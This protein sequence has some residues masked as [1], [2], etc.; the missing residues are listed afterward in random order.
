MR[1]KPMRAFV[2]RQ[3]TYGA[4]ELMEVAE[5][6]SAPG[7]VKI[8]IQATALCGSD[9]HADVSPIKARAVDRWGNLVYRKTGRNFGPLM[10]T[11]ARCTIVQ[12]EEIVELGELD[13]ESIVTPGIFVHRIV[14][15]A[16]K[17]VAEA[18]KQ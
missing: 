5:P 13:P 6:Q 4:V 15:V 14:K 18:Q 10:A 9:L 12:V 11:A 1:N 17:S 8:K 7:Q 2:K 3:R 16:R